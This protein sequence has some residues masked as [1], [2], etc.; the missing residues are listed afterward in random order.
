M[1]RAGGSLCWGIMTQKLPN[2]RHG[3][4]FEVCFASECGEHYHWQTVYLPE[5]NEL[6]DSAESHERCE[7]DLAI[8]ADLKKKTINDKPSPEDPLDAS[9]EP[10]L[11]LEPTAG[12][13]APQILR[14]TD[15]GATEAAPH[16]PGLCTMTGTIAAGRGGL[17]RINI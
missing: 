13:C 11:P 1:R 4:L 9:A 2:G 7:A 14:S 3:E 15:A 16:V 17:D 5:L 10:V 12:Y 8:I 6:L